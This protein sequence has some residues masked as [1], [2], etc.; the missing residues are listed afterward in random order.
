MLDRILNNWKTTAAGLLAVASVVLG[1]F[2]ANGYTG[3]EFEVAGS[4]IAGLGLLLAK[5]K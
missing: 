4:I 3:K 1:A 5:D 2:V